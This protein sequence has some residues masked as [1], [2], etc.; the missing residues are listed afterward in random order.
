M[1]L[2]FR[3]RDEGFR[4]S[5]AIALVLLGCGSAFA[6]QPTLRI[7]R[8]SQ[9]PDIEQYLDGK[10]PAGQTPVTNFSQRDPVDGA[11]STQ[12][13]EAYASYDDRH[14]YV[15]FVCHDSEPGKV[16]ARLTRREDF[17]GDDFVG[18]LLDTFHDRRRAYVFIT[19]P[20]GIQLDGVT[21][22][23]QDDDFSFDTLWRSEGRLTPFGYVV[24]MEIPFKSLRFPAAAA[25]TWGIAFAREIPRA[26]ETSFWPTITNRVQGFGQQ[27]ATLEGLERISPGRNIQLIPYATFAGA[28]FLDPSGEGYDTDAD[29]RAGLDAKF[30]LKDAF[31]LDVTLNPDFS[32]VESDEPQVTINQRF[33]VF[34]P[35]RRPFFIENAT[36]FETPINLMFSRRIADPQFGTRVTGKAGGWAL[37]ALAIDD[38]APGRRLEAGPGFGNRAGVGIVRAQRE[39]GEQSAVGVL[40]TSRDFGPSFSRVVSADG[41][42]KL[43][44]NWVVLGQAAFSQTAEGPTAAITGGLVDAWLRR[45]SRTWGYEANYRDIGP[46][47]SA[48]LGFVRRVDIRSVEQ[49][50]YRNWFPGGRVLQFGP[51]LAAN[52][53]WDHA[54]TLQD[55]IVRPEFSMQFAGQTG[56]ELE[57]QQSM[58]RFEGLEFRKHSTGL[59]VSSDRLRWLSVSGGVETG[60][61]INFFP[62]SGR[63]P[64]LANAR[65]A[66]LRI[67]LRP[68]ARLRVE[69][70]YLLSTLSQ[71][72]GDA[73]IFTNHIFRS[74]VNYQ[75]SRALSLRAILDYST[76]SADESLIDESRERRFT[77]DLLF[78]YLLN[79]GTAVYVGYTDR[80]ARGDFDGPQTALRSTGRQVFVKASYLLRF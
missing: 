16:R 65:E 57:H 48:P 21:A 63:A 45:S 30:V 24:R 56:L 34:F 42:V 25:Q 4:V 26:N 18:I 33:E 67:T 39:F 1:R 15:I 47:F 22:E 60:T 14:L 77:G 32:Q 66:S 31:T 13:T 43:N 36:Y 35:E 53:I 69:Q 3:I 49:A 75:F 50:A 72:G 68:L 37:G 51:E 74:R 46:D 23:G 59:S 11:P 58:E 61:E 7:T 8:V 70:R 9:P 6:Q 54:G 19:N 27:L 41:R 76:V 10:A 71:R 79:P 17:G 20:Y 64:F 2:A 5:A 38:R 55:W 73:S 12:R 62:G 29:G 80:Y 44:D 52:A 40:A 28:R 78:T